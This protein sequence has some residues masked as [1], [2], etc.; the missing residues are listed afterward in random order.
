MRTHDVVPGL[1][2]GALEPAGERGAAEA[3]AG[4][5]VVAAAAPV[6]WENHEPVPCVYFFAPVAGL[7]VVGL[8]GCDDIGLE[9]ECHRDGNDPWRPPPAPVAVFDRQEP[10]E[11][12]FAYI[13]Q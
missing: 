11:R 10:D 9:S 2:R 1:R 7:G 3:A 12:C 6:G 4:R 13:L 5:A 8:V